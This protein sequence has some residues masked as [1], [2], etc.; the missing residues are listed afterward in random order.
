MTI[1]ERIRDINTL[2]E[3]YSIS[4]T[5]ALTAEN[6]DSPIAEYKLPS[7]EA[8]CQFLRQATFCGREHQK[9]FVVRKKDGQYV[10]IGHCCAYKRL[11]LEHS[12]IKDQFSQLS[13]QI[14]Q[15][16]KEERIRELLANKQ[17][18]QTTVRTCLISIREQL[19][20]IDTLGTLLPCQVVSSLVERARANN[21]SVVWECSIFKKAED[22][23]DNETIRVSHTAGKIRGLECW[24]ELPKIEEHKK[25]LQILRKSLFSASLSNRPTEAELA[26]LEEL[27]QGMTSLVRIQQDVDRF[28]SAVGRFIRKD[29]LLLLPHSISNH[30]HRT[31]TLRAI[32]DYCDLPLNKPEKYYIADFDR[33]M[34][35]KYGASGIRLRD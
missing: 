8:K 30:N 27:L 6:F 1:K 22:K 14:R 10:L 28:K 23:K 5:E 17:E 21:A 7:G 35:E 32:S 12:G 15:Y 34:R 29:N 24:A 16:E 2:H 4:T 13:K 26:E 18:H 20:I 33:S 11:G 9:G 31:A 19:E 25:S 3:K